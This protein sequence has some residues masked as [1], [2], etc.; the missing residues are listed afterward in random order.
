MLRAIAEF[1]PH[2]GLRLP[3]SFPYNPLVPA[4]TLRVMRELEAEVVP[5]PPMPVEIAARYLILVARDRV[6]L[7]EYLQQ[8]F[9]TETDVEVR[10]ERRMG[11]RRRRPAVK[12]LDR[13]RRDRRAKPPLD[14]DLGRFGFAIIIRGEGRPVNAHP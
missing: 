4:D 3:S 14:A 12:P 8:K 6:D 11:E 7:F 1:C 9:V 5:Q 2:C 13:R 10:Y